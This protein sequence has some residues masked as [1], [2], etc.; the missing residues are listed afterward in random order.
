MANLTPEQIRT[1]LETDAPDSVIAP[2]LGAAYDDCYQQLGAAPGAQFIQHQ[3]VGA[4]VLYLPRFTTLISVREWLNDAW[5]AVA[6]SDYVLR[7]RR[8]S[9]TDRVWTQ[10]ELTLE[11]D[12]T[13]ARLSRVVVGLVAIGLADA[14][15]RYERLGSFSA[16]YANRREMRS[17]IL[18]E[19]VGSTGFL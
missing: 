9:R 8:L 4:N 16:G 12:I 2:I 19:L 5:A 18:R 14:N 17:T 13:E 1:A 10:V 7:G 15:V 11:V 6:S 3:T